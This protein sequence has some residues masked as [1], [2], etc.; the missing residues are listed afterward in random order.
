MPR[1]LAQ[2]DARRVAALGRR[3]TRLGHGKLQR[4]QAGP[5]RR[6]QRGIGDGDAR[7][8]RDGLPLRDGLRGELDGD[9]LPCA[10]AAD[11]HPL[12]RDRA[13]GAV[14]AH[15]HA[16]RDARLRGAGGVG[17]QRRLD[18]RFGELAFADR[19]HRDLPVE[20]AP[21]EPRA[22]KALLALRTGVAPVDP[23]DER[24]RAGGERGAA[25]EG[26]VGAAVGDDRPAVDEGARLEV[27]RGEGEGVGAGNR[28][29][30]AR[31]IPGDGARVVA[32]PGAAFDVE[33]VDVIGNAHAVAGEAA[34]L[35]AAREAAVAGIERQRP[36]RQRAAPAG[37]FADL[38]SARRRLRR[39]RRGGEGDA[40]DQGGDAAFFN[41]RGIAMPSTTS[42]RV[43]SAWR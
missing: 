20:P 16:D 34:A 41:G 19:A 7:L 11:Q 39:G 32:L 1:E 27:G 8:H 10:R 25:F 17:L 5:A 14:V 36:A 13:R 33:R 24:V 18:R 12:R 40:G 6:P 15:V 31:A 42:R 38:R 2:S 37:P 43:R 21:V 23:H 22:V 29:R 28:S 30:D 9:A 4:V 26:Q 3:G 35:P